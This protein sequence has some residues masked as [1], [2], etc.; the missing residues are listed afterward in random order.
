MPL[1]AVLANRRQRR[2]YNRN[3]IG[4]M[5]AGGI[6]AGVSGAVTNRLLHN[7]RSRR[8]SEGFYVMG[9]HTSVAWCATQ[10]E[11]NEVAKRL[12]YRGGQHYT[13]VPAGTLGTTGRSAA[14]HRASRNPSKSVR[15]FAVPGGKER[16]VA[17]LLRGAFIWAQ[18]VD[19]GVMTVARPEIVKR[20][21]NV[22]KSGKFTNPLTRREAARGLLSARGDYRLGMDYPKGS[23]RRKFL[24]GRASGKAAMVA[25]HGQG[26]RT[27]YIAASLETKAYARQNRP[28]QGTIT[29][30]FKVGRKY[31]VESIARWVEAHGTPD[32]KKRFA[33]ALA[34][35]KRFHKG[36]A[37]DYITYQ[38]YKMGSHPGISDVEFGVSE[39]REWMAAYQV[40]RSS[41]KWVDKA[42]AGRYV[43]AHGDSEIDVD[44][45]KP[46]GLKKLPMRFHTPDGKSVGVI[47]SK[48]VKIG[49][50]YE[51]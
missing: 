49:E 3:M 10:A 6:A 45:K 13:V 51:G 2:R 24:L 12:N 25:D 16:S 22:V 29:I 19:G 41:G 50:W 21:I 20:A 32:M 26:H 28:E 47:P 38:P 18:A 14:A 40:T 11:A 48:N 42:S 31:S 8:N 36:S 4:P 46:V 37:P 44:V 5:I 35:Y 9:K 17:A 15:T 39:G 34:Q 27:R 33:Q 23:Q 1:L 43:H 30:P 7:G